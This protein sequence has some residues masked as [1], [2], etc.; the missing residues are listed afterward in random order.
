[1]KTTFLKDANKCRQVSSTPSTSTSAKNRKKNL[2]VEDRAETETNLE[3][4]NKRRAYSSQS[5]AEVFVFYAKKKE[6]AQ[7]NLIKG[8]L[9]AQDLGRPSLGNFY[10]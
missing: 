7:D 10:E 2:S 9:V 1:M 8:K 3:K 5:P 4:E 6:H